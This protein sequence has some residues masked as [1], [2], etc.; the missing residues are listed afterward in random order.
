MTEVA[1]LKQHGADHV[2]MG[3]KEIAEG[4]LEYAAAQTAPR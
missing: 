4:M 2:I 1:Y 3:E